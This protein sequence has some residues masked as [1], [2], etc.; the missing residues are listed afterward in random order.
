MRLYRIQIEEVTGVLLAG[1]RAAKT[2]RNAARG[3]ERGERLSVRLF[4]YTVTLLLILL[5]FI[6]IE[7]YAKGYTSLSSANFESSITLSLIFPFAVFSYLMAFRGQTFSFIV[8][9]LGLTKDRLTKTAVYLGLLLFVALLILEIGTGIL[10]SVTGVQLPTNTFVVLQG[11]PI[12]F[13]LFGI[14]VAPINEEI[15]FRGFLVPRI[16]ILLSAPIFAIFHIGYLSITEFA[17]AL[18]FGLLAG[19]V[20]KKSSSLYSTIIGHA[21]VN[22][23][24]IIAFLLLGGST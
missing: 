3:K 24:T 23:L 19:Y 15:F 1:K 5:T 11:A 4:F 16:G 18:I 13:L 10:E 21:A 17:A 7:L 6:S 14:F 2:K 9:G 20:F 8:K 22:A 12:Y